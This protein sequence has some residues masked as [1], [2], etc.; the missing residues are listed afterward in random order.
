MDHTDPVDYEALAYASGL[1]ALIDHDFG[2]GSVAHVNLARAVVDLYRQQ[3][4]ARGVVDVRA[5][6]L[7]GLIDALE[8]KRPPFPPYLEEARI[9]LLADST[10]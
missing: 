8:R 2:P 4:R 10:P 5:E 3:Q 6:V 7:R 1:Q 9:A